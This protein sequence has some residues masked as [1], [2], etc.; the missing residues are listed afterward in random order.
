M[1]TLFH[2]INSI[3]MSVSA[4]M[5]QYGAFRA[6]GLSMRQLERM[7]LAEACTYT[8]FGSIT[9]TGIGLVCSRLLFR[10]LITPRWGDQWSVPWG[11]LGVILLIVLLAVVLAV[12]N[13]IRTLRRMSIVDTISAQ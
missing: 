12:K 7:V 6:I 11:S 10:L 1:I 3:A 13:P 9:G 2:I 4:R 5:R 8:L